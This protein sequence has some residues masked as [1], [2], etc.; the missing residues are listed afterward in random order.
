[1]ENQKL[2]DSAFEEFNKSKEFYL[3]NYLTFEITNEKEMQYLFDQ[4]EKTYEKSID[5]PNFVDMLLWASANKLKIKPDTLISFEEH[6]RKLTEEK[7]E[8][9]NFYILLNLATVYHQLSESVKVKEWVSNS[10][11]LASTVD[12]YYHIIEYVSHPYSGLS[13]GDKSWG[14]ELLAQAKTKVDDKTYK[15]I[16]KSTSSLLN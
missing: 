15:K 12:D 5:I 4:A 14:C 8:Y 11:D 7:S 13:L 3:I 9:I 6:I 10:F 2:I 16:E 1:M